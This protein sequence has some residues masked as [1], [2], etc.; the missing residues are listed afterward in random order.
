MMKRLLILGALLVAGAGQAVTE[1]YDWNGKGWIFDGAPGAGGD[2]N[3]TTTQS[4][5]SRDTGDREAPDSDDTVIIQRWIWGTADGSGG[6]WDSGT[7]T[8]LSTTT[9]I[10]NLYLCLNDGGLAGTGPFIPGGQTAQ[11]DLVSGANLTAPSMQAAITSNSTA[12]LNLSGDAEMTVGTLQAVSGAGGSLAFNLTDEAELTLNALVSLDGWHITME[13]NSVVTINSAAGAGLALGG[14]I[15]AKRPVDTIQT[16]DLG[17]GLWQYTVIIGTLDTYDWLGTSTIYEPD[18]EDD[19]WAKTN[20]WRCRDT[21]ARELPEPG[22]TVLIQRYVQGN[23]GVPGG[24]WDSG[25]SAELDMVTVLLG[26]VYLVQADAPGGQTAQ[27][28][29]VGGAYLPAA[30]LIMA[31]V[32]G[33]TATL[34]MSSNAAVS[35]NGLFLGVGDGTSASTI[36]VN[37][38]GTSFINVLLDTIVSS[39]GADI[40]FTMDD[41]ALLRLAGGDTNWAN[42]VVVAADPGAAIQATDID[43]VV[44][45]A[46]LAGAP[47]PEVWIDSQNLYWTSA[48]GYL[49]SVSNTTDLAAGSWAEWTNGITATPGT[50]SVPLPVDTYNPA[51]FKVNAY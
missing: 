7:N 48:A 39:T 13:S 32:A 11:L 33:S 3:W 16:T 26:D 12:T 41:D 14:L 31:P 20:N 22:D 46:V 47:Q 34:N 1:T 36:R 42:T 24:A 45:F 23:D 4:W 43:G 29:M 40:L 35:V 49:Y 10:G 50:N 15:T 2:E 37:M 25:V 51:F 19:S 9:T 28:D 44:E 21:G 6:A 8:V 17:G 30:N 18:G 5:R 27:L 38:S